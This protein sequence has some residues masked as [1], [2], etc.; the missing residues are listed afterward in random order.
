MTLATLATPYRKQFAP[1]DAESLERYR[2][3][4]PG[5]FCLGVDEG[6]AL[7]GVSLAEAQEWNRSLWVWE[8]HVAERRKGQGI[9]TVLM[10]DLARRARAAGLRIMIC[11]TQNTN[12]PAIRFYR[13]MGFT[14]E[15]IDLSYYTNDD[16]PDGEI[17]VFMKRKL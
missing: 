1:P 5:E 16:W 15:G 7:V 11:E 12:V 4:V 13:R 10:E 2:R 6:E 14:V 8:F 3:M 9:G 17:A